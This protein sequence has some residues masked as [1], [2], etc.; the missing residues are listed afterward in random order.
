MENPILITFL[1]QRINENKDISKLIKEYNINFYLFGSILNSKAP[2][3]IDLLM[4]Y[5][6]NSIALKSI[7][8]LKNEIINYL[9]ES[10]FIK[11]DLLL[12][13]SEEVIE[14]NFIEKEKAVNFKL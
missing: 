12:L 3:D 6:P 1:Q 10:N 14:V 2:N 13:S 11:V 8:K 7:I 4:E 5:N 9:N